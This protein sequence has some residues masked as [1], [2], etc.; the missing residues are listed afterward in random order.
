MREGRRTQASRKVDAAEETRMC[1][2]FSQVCDDV[3]A[4]EGFSSRTD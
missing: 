3:I 2:L 4:G 1:R